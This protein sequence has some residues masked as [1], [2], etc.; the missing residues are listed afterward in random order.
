MSAHE[1]KSPI[2]IT[3]KLTNATPFSFKKLI[4]SISDHLLVQTCLPLSIRLTTKFSKVLPQ[5]LFGEQRKVRNLSDIHIPASSALNSLQQ[6]RKDRTRMLAP[7][8]LQTAL[9]DRKTSRVSVLVELHGGNGINKCDELCPS[10]S[11]IVQHI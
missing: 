3:H 1:K 2:T 9:H 10:V 7:S 4:I 8:D 11:L 6:R 5:F